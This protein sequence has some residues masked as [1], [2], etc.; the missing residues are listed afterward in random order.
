MLDLVVN[1]SRQIWRRLD[2]VHWSYNN[3]LFH[4]GQRN[5]LK[6][7]WPPDVRVNTAGH[8]TRTEHSLQDG[9]RS[10]CRQGIWCRSDLQRLWSRRWLQGWQD[11]AGRDGRAVQ[12]ERS[13][14]VGHQRRMQTCRA[15]TFAHLTLW[16]EDLLQPNLRW[17]RKDKPR[18]CQWHCW[19]TMSF[20]NLL[21]TGI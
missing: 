21:F 12:Q 7:I 15:G 5:S 10:V 6:W 11:P 8:W 3:F 17:W 14:R 20:M 13:D 9:R 2:N 18:L 19:Q 4:G 1:Q 16:I